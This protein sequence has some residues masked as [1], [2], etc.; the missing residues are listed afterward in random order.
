[1]GDNWQIGI[2]TVIA[3][4]AR[5]STGGQVSTPKYQPPDVL[6]A[7]DISYPLNT[8]TTGMVS[9]S[10]SLDGGG[11]LQYM[12]VVEDTPP[13]TAAAQASVRSWTFRGARVNGAGI[14]SNFPVSVVFNPYN[15]GGTNLGTGKL[16]TP[17]SP[18]GNGVD[19]VAPQILSASY[20]LYP[21]DSVLTGTVVL[22]VSVAPD[23]HVGKVKIVRGM[24][25]LTAAAISSVKQWG[26]Q[27][28]IRGRHAV[29]GR[30]CIAFVFQRNLT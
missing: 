1:M 27:P 26:F 9:L 16:T 8:T 17:I 6:T 2:F 30:I 5:A 21:L 19:Y 12:Q 28:A 18:T 13:L 25:P 14:A 20:A 24:Q 10:L 7:T 3:L 23:G 29:E 22:S 11:S 15:P 4:L